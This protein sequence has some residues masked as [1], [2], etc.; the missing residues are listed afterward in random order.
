MTVSAVFK[1]AMDQAAIS[2]DK[3]T[4]S[5]KQTAVSLSSERFSIFK[6][7]VLVH[8]KTLSSTLFSAAAGGCFWL[9]KKKNSG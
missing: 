8:T 3:R 1:A 6:L 2:S 4:E 7:I 9:K 5:Y